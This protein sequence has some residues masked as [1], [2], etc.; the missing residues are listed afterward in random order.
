MRLTRANLL[1]FGLSLL[2]LDLMTSVLKNS[3]KKSGG[4]ILKSIAGL[5]FVPCLGIVSVKDD[6]LNSL[7]DSANHIMN[8]WLDVPLNV[9]SSC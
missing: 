9:L 5:L 8:S 1:V 3:V 7:I 2:L 6:V 4:N